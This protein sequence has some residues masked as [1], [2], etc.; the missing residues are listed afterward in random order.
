V[1]LHSTHHRRTIPLA[2]LTLGLALVLAPLLGAAGSA[3]VHAAR[4]THQAVHCAATATGTRVGACAATFA[5][6]DTHGRLVALARYRGHPVLL[7]FWSTGC[8]YCAAEL[9]ALQAFA[10]AFLRRGG[11]ILGVDVGGEAQDVIAG[12]ARANRVAWPL[13]VDPAVRVGD[14]YAVRGTPTNVF[15]GRRGVIRA[16]E[17]GPLTLQDFRHISKGL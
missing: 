7:N 4:V 6:P 2:A 13:L 15:I 5:L 11:V 17:D 10:A 8:P 3:P 14:L 16:V 12:Y 1:G 9:P